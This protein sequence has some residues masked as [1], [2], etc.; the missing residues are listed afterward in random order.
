MI[1]DLSADMKHY[2]N[3]IMYLNVFDFQKVKNNVFELFKRIISHLICYTVVTYPPC[4]F[5]SGQGV[6]KRGEATRSLF[7]SKKSNRKGV[8]DIRGTD[9]GV[10]GFLVKHSE[11]IIVPKSFNHQVGI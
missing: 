7:V 5:M 6:M 11:I 4:F 10:G 3:L 2:V 9:R 1:Y 8:G